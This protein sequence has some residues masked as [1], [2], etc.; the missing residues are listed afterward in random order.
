M[1][2]ATPSE[3]RSGRPNTVEKPLPVSLRDLRH[4]K[5]LSL[6]E[7]AVRAGLHKGRLSE[8]ERGDRAAT[9]HEIAALEQ[10]YGVG[11]RV[12]HAIVVDEG[13]KA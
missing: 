13:E 7:A 2:A 1:T 6:T 5:G 4:E 9:R 12:V 10:T 11:L 3:A 8:L